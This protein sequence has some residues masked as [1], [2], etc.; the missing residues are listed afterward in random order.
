[1]SGNGGDVL[2]KVDV[3]VG[4]PETDDSGVDVAG[5]IDS[6]ESGVV[7]VVVCDDLVESAT[8]P[9]S[10]AHDVTTKVVAASNTWILWCIAISLV[11]ST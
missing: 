8:R 4:D 1:M 2:G 3:V 11:T 7:V 6:V 10:L 5:E 9:V